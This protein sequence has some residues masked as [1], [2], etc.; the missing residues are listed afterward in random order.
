MIKSLPKALLKSFKDGKNTIRQ[1]LYKDMK[2]KG[3]QSFSFDNDSFM[4]K[5]ADERSYRNAN[6][7]IQITDVDST[8]PFL[9]KKTGENTFEAIPRHNIFF[10]GGPQGSADIHL[11]YD[12]NSTKQQKFA[13]ID[14]DRTKPAQ[15]SLG[16]DGT[17]S[18]TKRGQLYFEDEGDA[19]L[20]NPYD[21]GGDYYNKGAKFGERTQ[22]QP[23]PIQQETP[24]PVSSQQQ[25]PPSPV[26][27]NLQL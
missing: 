12:V 27:W 18:V 19:L 22:S 8:K 14:W 9:A 26:M 7:K 5:M 1:G 6:P 16:N 3:Y 10:K 21:K 13:N 11:L 15:F 2:K 17:I 24:N 4:S 20:P 25:P 23:T